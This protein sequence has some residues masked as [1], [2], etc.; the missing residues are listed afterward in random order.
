MRDYEEQLCAS[1]L[2]N[3]EEKDKFLEMYRV[4]GMNHKEIENQNREMMEIESMI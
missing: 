2:N 4:P 1:K 3:L